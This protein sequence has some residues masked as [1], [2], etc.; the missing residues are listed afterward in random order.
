M[1]GKKGLGV[2]DI[3]DVKDFLQTAVD[4]IKRTATTPITPGMQKKN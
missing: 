4:N 3:E 1:M 2:D